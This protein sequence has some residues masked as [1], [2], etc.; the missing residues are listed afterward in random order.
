MH[1]SYSLQ[2]YVLHHSATIMQEGSKLVKKVKGS[3]LFKVTGE[4]GDTVEWLI[5]LKSGN[6]SVTKSPGK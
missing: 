2:F 6:G 3:F 1:Y 4:K 5:D